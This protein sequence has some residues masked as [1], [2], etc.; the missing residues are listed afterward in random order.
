MKIDYTYTNII[1]D[2]IS[3]GYDYQDPNREGTYRREIELAVIKHLREDGYPIVT[4]RKTYFKG[5]VGELLLF[6]KGSTD[7]RHYW[8]YG[9]RFWDSDWARSQGFSEDIVKEL[10]ENYSSDI[11]PVH[12]SSYN[13]GKIYA[14]QYKRQHSVFD[15]FKKNPLRTDL[16]V[17]SWQI[18]DLSDMCLI[19]CFLENSKIKISTG[20][21][22]NIQDV[23][24]GELV[25]TKECD[26]KP[27][28]EVMVNDY[29]DYIYEIRTH[30]SPFPIKSTKEHPFW[31]KDK[32]WVN[33]E[34]LK[35]G[36]YL[37]IP[38]NKKSEIPELLTKNKI[39][40]HYT[41]Q[42]VIKLDKKE[43][44][45]L[46][47][48]F[49]GDGWIS[50][51]K[52]ILSINDNEF[53]EINEYINQTFDI[54]KIEQNK[55]CSKYVVTNKEYFDIFKSFGKDA[56]NKLIPDFV[57]NG[58][59]ELIEEFITGYFK[60]DG[61][62]LLY[63]RKATTISDN[64]AFGMQ[65]LSA[66]IGKKLSLYY[67]NRPS[68]KIIENREVNQQNTYS[69]DVKDIV[70]N[71]TKKYLFDDDFMWVMIDSIINKKEKTKNI[72]VL[73]QKRKTRFYKESFVRM[74]LACKI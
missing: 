7:I 16:I 65:L 55:G 74:K 33:A 62:N 21:Y 52:I 41:K 43:Q 60:A 54:R 40:Q 23:R 69:L 72:F 61:C 32:Q 67:Q 36:D 58:P 59:K 1:D 64:I 47:G 10:Y 39:N 45:F 53:S 31:V 68:K 34:D 57:Q 11:Y 4:A 71:K 38:L 66:K 46:M 6:L 20:E 63:G 28:Y 49:L 26:Y 24:R 18:D 44:W 22:K 35:E 5:A 37:A 15:D 14:Y 2:I 8:N 29:D 30:A 70:I 13:M 51:N 12:E 25:L 19:P 73:L 50:G 17:N 27:V 42:T 3:Y 48:Y 56:K 9:I